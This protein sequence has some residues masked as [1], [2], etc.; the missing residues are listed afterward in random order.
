MP[1]N[2]TTRRIAPT[3][4]DIGIVEHANADGGMNVLFDGM[5]DAVPCRAMIQPS[6]QNQA[7]RKGDEVVVMRTKS[8]TRLG[9]VI[10]LLNRPGKPASK[11]SMPDELILDANEQIVLRVGDSQVVIRKDR[12]LIDGKE[13]ATVAKGAN[14]IR[15]GS[16]AIN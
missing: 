1:H 15:G 12:I 9:V 16:V 10:G 7:Y 3:K 4:L 11:P 13:I 8:K 14:R 2:T 6:A 5:D